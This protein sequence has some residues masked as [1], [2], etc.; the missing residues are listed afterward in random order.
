MESEDLTGGRTSLQWMLM[1]VSGL[2]IYVSSATVT[3]GL[4]PAVA[5]AAI[6]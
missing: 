1:S 2:V 3:F 5:A 4:R 6:T